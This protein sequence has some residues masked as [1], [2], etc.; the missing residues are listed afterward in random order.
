VQIDCRLRFLYPES[1]QAEPSLSS[2]LRG[3]GEDFGSTR[4]CAK[5]FR[6]HWASANAAVGTMACYHFSGRERGS[7]GLVLFGS[8]HFS[9][10]DVSSASRV[11]ARS[12][13]GKSRFRNLYCLVSLTTQSAARIPTA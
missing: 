7:R 4:R 8:L 9:D 13:R 10:V 12:E 1:V 5:C 2:L 11:A 3:T 6:C